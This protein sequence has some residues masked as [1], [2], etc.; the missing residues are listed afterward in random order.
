[1]QIVRSVAASQP[2]Y[3]A[4]DLSPSVPSHA[5][6]HRDGDSLGW[7]ATGGVQPQQLPYVAN[8][9]FG[10]QTD[11][12]STTPAASA[13]V[14]AVRW[15][16]LLANDASREAFQEAD[17]PLELEGGFLDPSDGQDGNDMTPLQ[18]A[19]RIIDGQPA[20]Q[21]LPDGGINP[22]NPMSDLEEESMWQASESI[23]LLHREQI[24]FEHFIHQICSWVCPL[25]LYLFGN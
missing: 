18:R 14:A 13:S 23:I 12:A 6:V 21:N 4:P 22:A 8:D 7:D 15:F 16:G 5:T 17:A 3:V 9:W 19:T 20:A 10:Q 11:S 2:P 1:M 25:S 24:L